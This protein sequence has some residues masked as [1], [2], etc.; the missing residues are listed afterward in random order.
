MASFEQREVCGYLIGRT[1]GKGMSGKYVFSM[2]FVCFLA[3]GK[4]DLFTIEICLTFQYIHI[5][6]HISNYSINNI[7]QKGEAWHSCH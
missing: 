4:T 3:I 7:L 5:S 1:L 6:E 2:Q